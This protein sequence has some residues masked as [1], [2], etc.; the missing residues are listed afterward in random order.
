MVA[1]ARGSLEDSGAGG[2]HLVERDGLELGDD[3]GRFDR[4]GPNR[5]S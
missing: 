5:L 3:F 2:A 4:G 1:R